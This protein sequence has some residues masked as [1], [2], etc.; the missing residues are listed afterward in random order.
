MNGPQTRESLANE[1][2]RACDIMRRD[3]NCT[4]IMEY[5]EHLAWLLFL[6]FLDAQEE[7]WEAQAQIAGRPYTPIID[8]EY[9]WRHWATKDWPA[10]EL[11]AFVHG[12]LIPYLRSLG[13]DPLRETIRSLFSER[14]V[15]VCASGYNLKDVIQIVN[16][17]NFHSQ[18]DI[19]TVSQ[20]Y[21]E[22]LRRL[23]NENRLAGEFY[24]PRPVVR[25]VV[26]L[27]DPQIGE[28]VYD[29]AC[30]TCGF[31]VEAYLW[32]KQKE[33]TIEDHRIL[34]ER[35]FFGQEK[36]PVPAFLGLVNMMLHGVTVPRV[37]RRNT[38]EENIRNVSERFDV[39]VT[40]PPFG[41]TEGRHIQQNFPIQS[42]ATEL[43]FLQHIMKKLKPRDGA[44][45]GMVVPEGTLFRGGAFAEVKRDLLEQFNL[46]TVVSLP[47]GTFAPYSDVKTALIFFER[48]GPTKEI[49]YYELPLPEGLK[50]F[51][52][53]NPIQ[54]EHFEEARKLWRGWDAYRKGLGPVEACLS[55]R[56]W[57]VPVEEVKKRGYDLTARNP[58]RSGGEELPSPVEI[59]AGL[60]EK[61][62]EILSIMEELSELLE[63]E[64]GNSSRKNDE[65]EE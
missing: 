24:T 25:F 4:G 50:K 2:W 8:S 64:K 7:E 1:I 14:N 55:E 45:C 16:E 43:L 53:G 49:W 32:M 15:I 61:E 18:D 37:M 13:G 20:V 26:E 36:K 9:R 21:E 19:F 27:V 10:D 48:P 31:L 58:N 38:L 28:A 62:R 33:R 39:V 44:R 46:H 51:S 22:L 41:G 11:L 60:L 59:V 3:N 65:E 35:T 34:Q 52:K 23:G 5:V 6:R 40:N 30:G 56:S 63:N 47:P 12:R 42:N 17:I 57:I 54:D 29:P